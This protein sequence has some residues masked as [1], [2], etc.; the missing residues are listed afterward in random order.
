M[1]ITS[2]LINVMLQSIRKA[3]RALA[4]DFHEVNK[5][6]S[7]YGVGNFIKNAQLHSRKIIYDCLCDYRQGYG[8][9]FD[10]GADTAAKDDYTWFISVLD[11]QV[12]F[13]STITYFALSI[14]LIYKD[15]VVAAVVD[16]PALQETFWV[17]EGLGAFI[18]DPQSRH[19]KMRINNK[20][21]LRG[22]YIDCYNVNGNLHDKLLLNGVQM[23]C[24][25]SVSLSFAYLAAGR[26]DALV[27][28]NINKYK[29]AM[30]KLFL[31]E[32]RG[33]I[34]IDNNNLLIASNLV[35]HDILVNELS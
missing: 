12:N 23:R 1:T 34:T 7:P 6:Q 22:A 13:T 5:L 24:M 28:S 2:P 21:S 35:L 32:S 27:C 19:I 10:E 17:G 20:Q 16:A 18:E 30:G 25:G 29:A 11:S 8:F 9:L 3:S 26:F 33:K 4:R 15:R 31:Q 14:C